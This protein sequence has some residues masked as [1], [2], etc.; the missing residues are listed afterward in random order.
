MRLLD[1]KYWL[2]FYHLTTASLLVLWVKALVIGAI[3]L[4]C[5]KAKAQDPAWSLDYCIETAI[6]NNIQVKR[7]QLN[8]ENARAYSHQSK[9]QLL[10][11]ING[12]AS[13]S[14]NFG[15]N[16]NPVTN[17]YQENN[18]QAN[19][20]SLNATLPIFNGLQTQF[21]IKETRINL[22]ASKEDIKQS[23]NEI[24][25][26]VIS[27][28]LDFLFNEELQKA[29]QWQLEN[30]VSKKAQKEK[31]V[32]AGISAPSQLLEIEA[33]QTTDE[34][35]LTIAENNM[36]LSKLT[37]LQLMLLPSETEMHLISPTPE[38]EIFVEEHPE[39]TDEIYDAASRFMPATKQATWLITSAKYDEYSAKNSRLP[40]LNLSGSIFSNYAQILGQDNQFT[41]QQTLKNNFGQ[42]VSLSLYVP[43]LNAWQSRTTIQSAVI[44]R[45]NAELNAVETQINLRQEIEKAYLNKRAAYKKYLASEK[46]AETFRET[47]R[48]S[49]HKL[50][51]GTIDLIEFGTVKNNLSKAE[52]DFIRAKYDYIF[53]TKIL[54]FYKNNS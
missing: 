23:K 47:F 32:N 20:F 9:A 3:F 11:T 37:L 17:T 51:A 41:F 22:E 49:E 34:L 44:N 15:R 30:T 16:I 12:S 14:Y 54:N 35:N 39:N 1:L 46:K 5:I 21:K 42:F 7:S 24:M 8:N 28:Y 31:S 36:A 52:S 18:I 10:P 43:I 6:K 25:L 33:L 29:A 45:K 27:A 13:H 38:A 19:S 40:K 4:F 50:D 26:R 2:Q 53:K 48:M